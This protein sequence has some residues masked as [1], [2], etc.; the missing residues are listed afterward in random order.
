MPAK[1]TKQRITEAALH[2][3]EENGFHAVTVDK[4]VKES[5]TSKGGFYHNFKSKDELLYTIHDSF[6]TY[7]IDKASEAHSSYHK[8][9]EKLY[10]TVR[11]FVKMFEVY[12]AHVTVFYQENL[13]LSPEYFD[14]IKK[15]R[16]I[17][18]DMMFSVVREGKE[19]GE[20][21]EEL[22]VPIASM[23][24]FGMINWTYKWYKSDGQ[25][26][27]NE[28]AD[29]YADMI[30]QSLLTEKARK[31]PAYQRFFLHQSNTVK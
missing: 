30:M 27:V 23:A 12:Q 1:S 15:K 20:F 19:K 10:E 16:D 24:I 8:P 26:S 22:P 17:Y 28:I 25:C 7:V 3:F 2:L 9:A 13:Y 14:R 18:K 6:I 29:I 11:S 4:I 31:E 5:N 21:R